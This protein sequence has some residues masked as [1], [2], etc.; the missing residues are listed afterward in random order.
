MHLLSSHKCTTRAALGVSA[1]AEHH[2]QGLGCNL[3]L[4]CC[5]SVAGVSG[6]TFAQDRPMWSLFNVDSHPVSFTSATCLC[7]TPLNIRWHGYQYPDL[8]RPP[9]YHHACPNFTAGLLLWH[10]ARMS[11]P[12]SGLSRALERAVENGIRQEET[13]AAVMGHCLMPRPGCA[14]HW[15]VQSSHWYICI[16]A[17]QEPWKT[18]ENDVR[19]K[20]IFTATNV[21]CDAPDAS[22]YRRFNLIFRFGSASVWLLNSRLFNTSLALPQVQGSQPS[23]SFDKQSTS[24]IDVRLCSSSC[25]FDLTSN[26]SSAGQ[27]QRIPLT[28]ISSPSGY[29]PRS[30]CCTV[31]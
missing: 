24:W 22:A 11:T 17:V 23:G 4:L 13:F 15:V 26:H 28:R 29:P 20:R 18:F 5:G 2:V 9:S 10:G 30:A 3:Y 31:R 27:Q 1:S 7:I 19:R 21:Y 12:V 6:G 8:G 16:P 25:E 14:F